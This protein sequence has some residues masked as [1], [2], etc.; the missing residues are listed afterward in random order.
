MSTPTSASGPAGQASWSELYRGARE[1]VTGL[2]MAHPE[3][4]NRPVPAT[5]GWRVHDVVAHL[6][7]AA[8]DLATG[9]RPTGG[10]TD[11]W[12]A[13]H[14]ARGRE[15]S[16]HHLLARWAQV[17]P[18]VEQVLD[19]GSAW[20]IILDAG[21]HEHDLRGALGDTAARDTELVAFGATA[22]IQTLRV[23]L[24]LTVKIEHHQQQVG[25]HTDQQ[26]PATLSTTRFE[27]FRWRLGRRSRRQ[28]AAM[29]WSIDP[30][31][32]LDHL[33]VFGPANS[34]LIE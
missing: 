3:A 23:P 6:A 15:A 2:V 33:C 13:T 29:D 19:A 21:A 9:W 14:V 16:T 30:T 27:T 26:H 1:R 28:L 12:T 5:P 10:P 8:E 17:G 25:P 18:T 34:D 31:P 4:T 11:D 24:P 32:Y 20:Q 22:L 7:G